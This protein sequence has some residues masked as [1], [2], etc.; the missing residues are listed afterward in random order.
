MDKELEAVV[1]KVREGLATEGGDIEVITVKDDILYVK[2]TGNC[3]T[4]P[5]S[6]LTMKNWVE[7]TFLEQLPYLKGVKQVS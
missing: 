3:E 6:S 7:K 2:L 5:M 4:C 1:N